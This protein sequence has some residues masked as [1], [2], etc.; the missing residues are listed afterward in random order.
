MDERRLL[1]DLETLAHDSMAGRRAGTPGA[2]RARRFLIGAFETRGIPSPAGGRTQPFDLWRRQDG[3]SSQ[4][5]NVLGLASGTVYPDR[6]LV[7][8]AHYDHLGVR[9]GE[10]FNGA[11]DNASGTAALLALAAWFG[12]HSARHSLLFVASDGEEI[13]LRGARAFTE[14]PPV[15]LE[16]IVLNVNLDMVSRSEAG[17]L[18]AAGTWHRPYLTAIVQAA[19]RLSGIKLLEGHDRPDLGTSQDWTLQSDHG[20]F[21]LAGVPFLYFG[22]EDHSDYHQPGDDTANITPRFYQEAVEAVLDA[23]LLADREGEGLFEARS[24]GK[25]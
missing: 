15:P 21:H 16:R 10:V 12:E 13:G 18:Y 19:A 7:V 23:L 2:E 8:T 20:A 14:D 17:E 25:P 24:G 9:G 3:A 5:V 22:V 6:Y 11:D 1:S 4:G